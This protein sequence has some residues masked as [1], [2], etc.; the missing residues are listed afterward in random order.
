MKKILGIA[1]LF[2]ASLFATVSAHA[3][4]PVPVYRYFNGFDHFY[5]QNYNELRGG[6]GV[7]NYE[8]IAYYVYSSQASGSTLLY[9]LWKNGVHLYTTSATDAQNFCLYNGWY[10][11]TSV[12]YVYTT[13]QTGTKP[14]YV[15]ANGDFIFYTTNWNELGGGGQGYTYTG[16]AFYTP[17]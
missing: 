4:T 3:Q 12:G 10:P 2:V 1:L 7:Y 14:V 6:N 13:P 15:Y 8:G 9:R 5:T 11:E 17:Y 16:I